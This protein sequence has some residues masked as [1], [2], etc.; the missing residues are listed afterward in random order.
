MTDS[1][2]VVRIHP[3][4]PDRP[5]PV[6]R[7]IETVDHLIRALNRWPGTARVFVYDPAL[8]VHRPPVLTPLSDEGPVGEIE[9]I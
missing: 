2:E 8:G 9:I 7:P 5:W 3:T 1:C 6:A 4:K